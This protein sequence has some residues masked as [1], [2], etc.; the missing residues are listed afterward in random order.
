VP[1]AHEYRGRRA[2]IVENDDLRVTMLE[3]GG[4][5]A[6]IFNKRSRINPLWDAAVGVD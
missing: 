2:A 6:E 1:G 4:H 5:I 3:E